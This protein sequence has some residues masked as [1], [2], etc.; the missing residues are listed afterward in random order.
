MPARHEFM[1]NTNALSVLDYI[2]KT[3]RCTRRSIEHGTG[4]SWAAVSNIISDLIERNILCEIPPKVTVAGKNP[5]YLDFVPN[6]NLTLGI[7]LNVEGVTVLLLNLRSQVLASETHSIENL[8][9]DQV[10]DQLISIINDFMKTNAFTADVLLGIG[11]AIQ[12]SVDKGGSVSLYNSF[13]K[14]WRNV[15][16]KQIVEEY[17]HVPVHIIHDPICIALAEQWTRKLSKDDDFILIRLSYGIGMS[18][19]LGGEPVFGHEGT[20]GELGHMVLNNNGPLCSCHNRGC[21]ECYC[22]IRGMYQRILIQKSGASEEELINVVPSVDIMNQV[23]EDSYNLAL[24]GD[25]NSLSLFLDAG[26][27]LGIGVANLINL[28][29]PKYVILTGEMLNYRELFLSVV[30]D[31]TANHAWPFSRYTMLIANEG[32]TQ[33]ALGA[34]LYYINGAFESSE[35]PLLFM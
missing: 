18:C 11:I 2:R 9:R 12:G 17:F 23:V 32:R 7:D 26:Y 33:A 34:A 15:P 30:E 1:R 5:N 10:I 28:F 22:S 20:A 14:N 29:N 19:I 31:C 21:L 8:E 6:K 16:L 4:L 25:V 13:F 24:A 3:D 35:S 27:Y